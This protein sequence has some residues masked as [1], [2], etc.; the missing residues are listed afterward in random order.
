MKY[1]RNDDD[2]KRFDDR[3]MGLRQILEENRRD[4]QDRIDTIK[5]LKA[6]RRKLKLA[7]PGLPRGGGCGLCRSDTAA[8]CPTFIERLREHRECSGCQLRYHE[9]GYRYMTQR[10]RDTRAYLETRRREARELIDEIEEME[11]AREYY[12]HHYTP[13]DYY[14]NPDPS[15]VGRLSAEL[16]YLQDALPEN[17]IEQELVR[18]NYWKLRQKM[19]DLF[20]A[21]HENTDE[22]RRLE[23]E[24]LEFRRHAENLRQEHSHWS[25]RIP[26]LEDTIP[27]ARRRDAVRRRVLKARKAELA[28]TKKLKAEEK[29]RAEARRVEAARKTRNWNRMVQEEAR[30]VEIENVLGHVLA[31]RYARQHDFSQSPLD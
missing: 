11:R 2:Q 12:H 25:K 26:Y 3:L 16:R 10:L 30:R 7:Y 17:E 20:M 4:Q 23:K 18:R 22:F 15:E 9:D 27:R 6:E 8:L 31:D 5:T 1:P 14:G 19:S 21:G 29:A 28:E 24:E 13:R